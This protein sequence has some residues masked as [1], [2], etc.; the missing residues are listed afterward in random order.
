MVFGLLV[1]LEILIQ[2]KSSKPQAFKETPL[3]CRVVLAVIGSISLIMSALL[4]IFSFEAFTPNTTA[5]KALKFLNLFFICLIVKAV[6]WAPFIALELFDTLFENI[7]LDVQFQLNP[8]KPQKDRTVKKFNQLTSHVSVDMDDLLEV[9]E[10]TDEPQ[11]PEISSRVVE[12]SNAQRSLVENEIRPLAIQPQPKIFQ[13]IEM[14][15]E[16][17]EFARKQSEELNITEY[18]KKIK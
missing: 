10:E 5:E 9:K 3:Y 4:I 2:V 14:L 8:I 12:M 13:E 18:E 1:D 6:C 15:D 17:E 7:Y 16:D 11:S